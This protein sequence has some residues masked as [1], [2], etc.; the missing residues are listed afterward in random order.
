MNNEEVFEADV[1]VDAA[2]STRVSGQPGQPSRAGE[3]SITLAKGGV[4]AFSR[5][6]EIE[7]DGEEAPLLGSYAEGQ[8]RRGRDPPWEE[9]EEFKG[10]PWFKRPSVSQQ[11]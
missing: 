1:G 9:E 10:L 8:D 7:N 2:I 4:G 11:L 5:S 3:G 6:P